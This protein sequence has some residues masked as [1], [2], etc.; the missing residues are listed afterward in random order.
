MINSNSQ[1]SSSEANAI[2]L[3]HFLVT[4][5]CE[6]PVECECI[7][8]SGYLLIKSITNENKINICSIRCAI[9]DVEDEQAFRVIMYSSSSIKFSNP[10]PSVI[11]FWIENINCLTKARTKYSLSSFDYICTIGRGGSGVVNLVKE[12]STGKLFAL[13]CIPK[14]KLMSP[15]IIQRAITERDTQ[16]MSPHP[17]ITRL[18]GTFQTRSSLYYVMQ[19]IAGGDLAFHLNNQ[20]EFSIEQI[21]ILIAE[22]VLAVI[23]I[24]KLGIVYRDLKPE[25]ILIC[26]EGHIKL[27]DFGLAKELVR[28]A[29]TD[30][31]C[32]SCEYI[33][34]EIIQHKKYG[35]EVDWWALGVLLFRLTCGHT[36]FS[37]PLIPRLYEQIISRKVVVP[38]YIDSNASDLILK[39]LERDPEQRITDNNIQNHPFFNSINWD[40]VL[41]KK[42]K[43]EFQPMISSP[44]SVE[45]FDEDLT[46]HLMSTEI[47]ESDGN[48]F[49]EGF[50]CVHIDIYNSNHLITT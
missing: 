3:S 24:H 14:L 26:E 4:R 40:D 48:I 5:I 38:S 20:E 47:S 42:Y 37:H 10:D 45:N 2:A 35:V 9:E 15:K 34:P 7:L 8:T 39:L 50:S 23:H 31:L 6:E 43:W 33:A 18:Y 49:V 13:K 17:F 44:E 29:N 25:N 27:T 22:L 1:M 16:M 41:E 28:D 11:T 12:K 30:S 36:P 32:G 21:R 46:S 19:F